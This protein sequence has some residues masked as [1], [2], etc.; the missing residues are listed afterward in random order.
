[1]FTIRGGSSCASISV[2]LIGRGDANTTKKIGANMDQYQQR[3][4]IKYPRG[5]GGSQRHDCGPEGPARTVQIV[6]SSN[7]IM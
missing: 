1:M 5:S 4:R 2:V 6:I 7:Y 3:A